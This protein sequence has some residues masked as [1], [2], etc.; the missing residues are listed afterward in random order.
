MQDIMRSR[1]VSG[2]TPTPSSLRATLR[3]GISFGGYPDIQIVDSSV[4]LFC[5][6]PTYAVRHRLWTSIQNPRLSLYKKKNALQSPH[7]AVTRQR[8]RMREEIRI[9]P[10]GTDRLL[11]AACRTKLPVSVS[12]VWLANTSSTGK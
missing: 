8:G 12:H 3:S 5:D 2:D 6:V 7:G 1:R 9:N 4:R 10:N 11:H